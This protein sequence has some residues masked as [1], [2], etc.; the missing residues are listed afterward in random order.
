MII[1]L[2][3][4]PAPGRD[5]K[6]VCVGRLEVDFRQALRVCI[7]GNEQDGFATYACQG[8]LS[9]YL[10][11]PPSLLTYGVLLRRTH[12]AILTLSREVLIGEVPGALSGVTP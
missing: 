2:Y 5:I 7:R 12:D 1:Q 4:P 9:S 8:E 3:D 11:V 6:D 10:V